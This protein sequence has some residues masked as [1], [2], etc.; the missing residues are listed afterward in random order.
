[1]V[2]KLSLDETEARAVEGWLRVPPRPDEVD[3]QDIPTEHRKLF[4]DAVRG[5]IL[6]DGEVDPEERINLSLLEELLG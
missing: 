2:K 1:M 3:P 6:A 4:L 5:I